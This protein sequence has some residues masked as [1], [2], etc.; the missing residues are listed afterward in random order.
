MG[1]TA[2]KTD[3]KLWEKV[4]EEVTEAAKAGAA[5]SGRRARS[6][7]SFLSVRNSC[8]IRQRNR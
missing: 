6:S 4:K 7:P 2:K 5:A 8:S 1:K 3:P